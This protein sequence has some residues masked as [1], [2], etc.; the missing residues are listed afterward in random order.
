MEPFLRS[1]R[2]RLRGRVFADTMRRGLYATDASIYQIFPVAAAVPEDAEDVRAALLVA[3]E[4]RVPII[5][6]GAGTSL[7]GQV[8]GTALVL[9]LSKHFRRVLEVNVEERWARVEPGVV[10]DELN[11][12]LAPLG[13]HF[14]PDPAT[15]NRATI[16]GMIGN[17]A[18]GMRSIRYGM[19]IHHVEETRALLADGSLLHTRDLDAAARARIERDGGAEGR[20]LG[21][22]RAVVD[23]HRP[24][25]EER[26]P[27]VMRKVAGYNLDAFLS[28]D[29]W[30]L[31]NLLVGSEGTLA[32]LLEARVRL[33]PLPAQTILCVPHF[34]T[35]R[36]ALR[37]V[38]A[39]LPHDPS[40]IEVLDEILIREA[41][42]NASTAA[43][44]GFLEKDPRAV[45]LVEFSGAVKDEC[46]ARARR[47]AAEITR[48][49][50]SFASPVLESRAAQA[51][52]WEVRRAGLGLAQAI[53][54]SRKPVPFIE[55]A[56]VPVE[57]LAD[58]V[59]AIHRLCEE[60][61][62]YPVLYGHA[63]VGV[64]HIKPVLDL[65]LPEDVRAM[66]EIARAAFDLVRKYGGSWSG[67]HG[68]GLVRS[69]YLEEFF[70]PEVYGA[71]RE[72]KDL[73]DPLRILNPGKIVDA[74]S[75]EANLRAVPETHVPRTY[76]HYRRAGGFLAAALLCNGV[77]AC[78]KTLTGT[79]CPSYI[80][81]RDEEHSTRGRANALRLA[82]S[83][84]L[85]TNGIG[86]EALLEV[87]DLCLSCKACRS[88]CP[89]NVDVARFKAEV[90]QA[91]RDAGMRPSLRERIV[92]LSPKLARRAAGPLAPVV[93][94]VQRTPIFRALLEQ[95]AGFDRRRLLPEYARRPLDA[96]LSGRRAQSGGR[97]VVLFDDTYMRFHEPKVGIAAFDL[98]ESCGYEVV[99]ARAGCCQRPRLSHGFL[100]EAKRD[101]EK[102]LRNL[103]RFIRE[104]WPVV[105]CE[106]GCASA[107]TDDLPDLVDD[108]DLAR[109]ASEGIFPLEVF[110]DREIREG[111]LDV[112]LVSD[113]A[114][115]ALHG[116]CHQ[117]SLHGTAPLKRIYARVEGL[118]VDEIDSGC[119]GMAGSF[120]YEKEHYELSLRVGEDRLFP[121]LRA[122]PKETRV[123]ASGFSCRHQIAHGVGI[124]AVHWVETL[125]AA[126]EV[127]GRS[128]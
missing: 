67:E 96:A 83:G 98:L 51:N 62:T 2:S 39:I 124:R 95:A 32:L 126:P 23:R 97:K 74:P 33:E 45:L 75:P 46:L 110:L 53:P 54:G 79:M 11:A 99:L 19:T 8:A 31:S 34:V 10:R 57:H 87:F 40:A 60:R 105:V 50:E 42:A 88:E 18:S 22:L 47:F 1:L 125:R 106:P 86:A 116:H 24:K 16:G 14:A 91:C 108:E 69:A 77:G 3:A 35:L 56:C 118:R 101:G 112:R 120:G 61:G 123:V 71:F 28:N 111:R 122:L 5:P 107:L 128:A 65:R 26:F 85:G 44:S 55:D 58:Y 104:G 36:A 90:Q 82:M 48:N 30:N 73:F 64:L 20:I 66:T 9:D 80:A 7:G 43:L 103:D 117:K 100:R 27:K 12:T 76:Y 38:P 4:H 121:A 81:T 21:G 6:R 29:R 78:R 89:S 72:V 84:L 115:I 92:A 63:S 109:R 68:D 119:C 52:A 17:N 25:I 41:R 93:N 13:L 114:G 59:D 94:A 127:P 49:G 102:A 37:A 113:A 15:T 70:G